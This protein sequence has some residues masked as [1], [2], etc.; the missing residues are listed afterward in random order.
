MRASVRRNAAASLDLCEVG[1][2]AGQP[3]KAGE[4][5]PCT[6]RLQGSGV[7]VAPCN[8]DEGD[9][10]RTGGVGIADFVADADQLGRP[11]AG[12]AQQ[13]ARIAFLITARQPGGAGVCAGV[14]QKFLTNGLSN[15]DADRAGC[16]QT[17]K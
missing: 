10:H 2:H 12:G 14:C 1:K 7:S 6:V 5:R 11:E 17:I 9:A 8:A 13:L 3:G 16:R 4:Q 15:S